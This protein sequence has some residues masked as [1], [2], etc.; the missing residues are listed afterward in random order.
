MTF[1]LQKFSLLIKNV[2]IRI[3]PFYYLNAAIELH[4]HIAMF[5]YQLGYHSM[6][7]LA[8]SLLK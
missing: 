4:D 1:T 7:I 2:G 6:I 5:S 8:E 3:L